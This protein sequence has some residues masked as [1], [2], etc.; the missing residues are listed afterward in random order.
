MA[1]W[2]PG[3]TY[4]WEFVGSNQ[5]KW[6]HF[7]YLKVDAAKNHLQRNNKVQQ[8]T[9]LGIS[10]KPTLHYLPKHIFIIKCN[11][12]FYSSAS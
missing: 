6:V 4:N 11:V 9:L 2:S 10:M 7:A 12:L 5:S 3:A 8:R 1:M